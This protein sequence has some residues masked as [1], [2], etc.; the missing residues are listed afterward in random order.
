MVLVVSIQPGK[1]HSVDIHSNSTTSERNITSVD[2]ILNLI[3]NMFPPNLYQTTS[4]TETTGSVTEVVQTTNIL[5]LVVASIT[6]GIALAKLGEE[7]MMTI[8]TWVISLSPIGV[9]FFGGL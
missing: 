5:G 9:M 8:T 7:V 4:S 1:G 6:I 3:K 2:T